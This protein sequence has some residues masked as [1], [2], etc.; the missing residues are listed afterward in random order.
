MAT[1]VGAGA[2]AEAEA[3]AGPQKPWNQLPQ[4][5]QLA[6]LSSLVLEYID[7]SELLQD[8]LEA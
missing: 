1:P 3:R 8:N 7:M 4:K 5:G 2:K 6:S